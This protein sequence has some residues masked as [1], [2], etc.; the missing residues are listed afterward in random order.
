M[1]ACLMKDFSTLKMKMEKN[2]Q[3]L[4]VD[5]E[6]KNFQIC[7]WTVYMYLLPAKNNH[8]NYL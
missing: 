5:D 1:S 3:E 4:R 6:L 2:K 8:A 7:D